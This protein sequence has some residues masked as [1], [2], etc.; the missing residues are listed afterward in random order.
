MIKIRAWIE[1]N[2]TGEGYMFFPQRLHQT[3]EHGPQK[4]KYPGLS[5]TDPKTRF[6]SDKVMLWTGNISFGKE[7]YVGD[8][9]CRPGDGDWI[10]QVVFENCMFGLRDA[11]GC[12][13]GT[14]KTGV[15]YKILGNIYANPELLEVKNG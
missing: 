10:C 11:D 2:S 8:I 9:V 12:W 15:L 14:V 1:L 6:V 5:A 4:Y 3:I 13:Q 7:L